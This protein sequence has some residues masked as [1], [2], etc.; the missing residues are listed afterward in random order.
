[1][2]AKSWNSSFRHHGAARGCSDQAPLTEIGEQNGGSGTNP[3]AAA[4]DVPVAG[5]PSGDAAQ[6]IADR[7]GGQHT[8]GIYLDRG[9]HRFVVTVTDEK[10]AAEVKAA[11]AVPRQV[12]YDTA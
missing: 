1:M 9:K 2:E 4:H 11:G 8:A 3:P 7:L 12:T 6:R 10:A 5:G